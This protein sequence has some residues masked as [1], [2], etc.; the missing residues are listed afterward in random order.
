MFL[1]SKEKIAVLETKVS[2]ILSVL[3]NK[4]A[5]IVIE[6]AS[7]CLFQPRVKNHPS[8][9]STNFQD[10]IENL[11]IKIDLILKH[12][13]LTIEPVKP[14]LTLTRTSENGETSC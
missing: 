7:A 9:P 11:N 13:G 4:N 14:G 1:G 6:E 5:K 8:M 12:F 3:L 10:E 2:H